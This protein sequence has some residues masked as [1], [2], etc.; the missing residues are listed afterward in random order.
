M[1]ETPKLHGL[2]TKSHAPVDQAN[3]EAL[4][5]DMG[6]EPGSWVSCAS[7]YRWYVGMCR[8][9]DL[10]PLSQNAFGRA[11]TA[12]GYR[13]SPRRVDDKVVRCRFMSGKAFPDHYAPRDHSDPDTSP[14]WE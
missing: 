3:V 13:S 5:M 11:M 6:L 9:E 8:E 7:L 12:L 10:E 14:G 1:G 4:V 2:R